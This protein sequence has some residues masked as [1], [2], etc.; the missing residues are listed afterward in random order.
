MGNDENVSSKN[1]GYPVVFQNNRPIIITTTKIDYFKDDDIE[2]KIVLQN[3]IPIVLSDI[4]LNLYLLE[5]WTYQESQNQLYSDLN[6]QPL[7]CVKVG[8]G[9]ILNINSELINL[10]T[11][12]FNFPFKFRLPNYLQPCFEYPLKN[13]RGYLRYSLEAKFVSPYTQGS[14]SIYLT[15][16]ARPN[17]FNSP[18]SY[19]SVMNVHKWG[20][21]DQ[22]TTQLKV[23][24]LT[25][26]YKMKDSI[27]LN[28]EIN[29]MRGKLKV[30]T[31]EVNLI[32][33]VVFK[34]K[35]TDK[36]QYKTED[37]ITKKEF[38]VD[39]KPKNQ[40]SMNILIPIEDKYK[41]RFDYSNVQNPYP[42]IVD[43]E[44]CMPSTDGAIIKCEY[45]I[46]VTLFFDSFVTSGY[47][48]KVILPISLT[49][50]TIDE[51]RLE[52]Q[53]DEDLKT[54]IEISKLEIK[55]DINYED[56]KNDLID[57]DNINI[58][59]VDR[60]K[61]GENID[62]PSGKDYEKM[63]PISQSQNFRKDSDN[64]AL[65]SKNEIER[66]HNN[67]QM[68]NNAPN[69]NINMEQN[70]I[71]N[72]QNNNMNYFDINQINYEGNNIINNNP[73]PAFINKKEDEEDL[74]NPY[75]INKNSNN[76][77]NNNNIQ[78]SNLMPKNNINNINQNDNRNQF[79]YNNNN[80][81]NYNNNSN[82]LNNNNKNNDNNQE[83]NNLDS[84]N[85]QMKNEINNNYPDYN[86]LSNV[87]NIN[88]NNNN[89]NFQTLKSDN[90]FSVF[91]ENNVGN[92]N[93]ENK[94]NNNENNNYYDINEL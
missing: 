13:R 90:D 6:R 39:V 35:N 17:V 73:A 67:K 41:N 65:P 30:T 9:K 86:K 34:N 75:M 18:L 94:P 88:S 23:S 42:N 31:L 11:G 63:Q 69:N 85:N 8:I 50:Q 84:N 28:V 72:N 68:I 93:E 26:N 91:G 89:N 58:S 59:V 33:K 40:H 66:N 36:I 81:P 2:G 74:F 53:E 51:F 45:S 46:S 87:N 54:A 24:Y 32:R 79:N 12:V 64:N 20:L 3:Q 29:N 49:H 37:I 47:L 19:S 62:K 10:S 22:G 7:L 15:I 82:H 55:K 1:V 5:G 57:N 27:P 92:S 38:N 4:Y 52:K 48:P 80:Y 44:Y 83:Y 76:D 25:N 77:Q 14:T 60:N 56:N 21:I 71:N 78:M 70:Y 16:K 43:I 61:M